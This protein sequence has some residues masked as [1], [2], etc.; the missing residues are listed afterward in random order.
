[1][2]SLLLDHAVKHVGV[3][4]HVRVWIEMVLHRGYISS[5]SVTLHVRVWIEISS[6]ICSAHSILVTLHV[7]VWIEMFILGEI[8]APAVS[9][10]PREGVD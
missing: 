5:S 6:G 7:R 10:P 9:H 1:M 2:K 3:T 8:Q 4:L